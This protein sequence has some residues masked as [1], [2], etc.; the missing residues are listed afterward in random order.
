MAGTSS[1]NG[2]DGKA[3]REAARLFVVSAPSGA[4]KTTLCR[5]VMNR[6]DNLRYS[7]SH[8]TRAPRPGETEGVDYFFI[9]RPAFQ[10]MIDRGQLVEWAEVHG[11]WYGTSA[12][13]LKETLADGKHLILDI[14]VQG[15]RQIRRQFPE[16]VKIFIAPPDMDTLRQRLIKRGDDTLQE[17]ER[18][19][20]NAEGEMASIGEYDHVVI[21]DDL[22]HALES[23]SAIFR[24]NGLTEAGGAGGG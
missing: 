3:H 20:T 19:M 2:R 1:K 8:T 4:G 9:D 24:Q 18:R 15:A 14:D 13:F 6:F 23:L 5:M 12:R 7:I 17:I 16:C 10:E 22:D 21:N 11:N